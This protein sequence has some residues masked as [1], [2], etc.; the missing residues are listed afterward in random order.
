[1]INPDEIIDEYGADTLRMY[2]MFMGPLDADK[3][4]NPRAV[5]GVSRFLK[6]YYTYVSNITDVKIKNQKS[7]PVGGQAKIKI[8]S[9]NEKLGNIEQT[10][11]ELE[12]DLEMTRLV[13]KTLKKVSDDIQHLKFNTA[14]AAMME[15]MN[16]LEDG[17]K[18]GK[19]VGNQETEILIKLIAPMAPYMAEE[20]WQQ[21]GAEET[22]NKIQ[23]TNNTQTTRSKQDAVRRASDGTE[24]VHL[25]QWPEWERELVEEGEVLVV[26]Q[27]NGKTR[28]K[29]NIQKSKLEEEMTEDTVMHLVQDE[30][31]VSRWIEGKDIRKVIWVEPK[32]GRQ[33]LINLVVG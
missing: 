5:A 16:G 13:H 23:V 22:N 12:L 15:M 26:V 3:P 31:A 17:W 25:T 33:G 32:D 21:F 24:S 1:V 20:M 19:G 27:V 2:E 7:T 8:A 6:R 11:I 28:A 9:Q 4:W 30:P 14:I 29:I 10:G 18:E